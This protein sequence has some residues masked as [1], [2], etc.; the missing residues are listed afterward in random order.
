MTDENRAGVLTHLSAARTMLERTITAVE[1]GDD[2]NT[3]FS[4]IATR[5]EQAAK[6]YDEN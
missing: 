3:Y 1:D 2:K 6:L 4:S 5:V